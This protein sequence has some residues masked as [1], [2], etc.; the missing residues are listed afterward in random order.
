MR[1]HGRLHGP[2]ERW[3]TP[4]QLSDPE[5]P[6]AEAEPPPRGNLLRRV[7]AY[8]LSRSASEGM[9]ALR[10]VLLATILVPIVG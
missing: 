1:E 6:V 3:S 9:L 8:A 5:L 7:L 2:L 10:G 4:I